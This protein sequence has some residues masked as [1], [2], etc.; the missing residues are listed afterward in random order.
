MIVPQHDDYPRE[1][2][3]DNPRTITW[4]HLSDLHS[5]KTKTGWDAHRVLMSL[6]DDLASS[7]IR[8]KLAAVASLFDHHCEV[9]AVSH[10]PVRGIKRPKSDNNEG[11]TPAL[12]GGQ[13]RAL[14]E[15]PPEDTLKGNATR[16]S[17]RRFFTTACG[18]RSSA[19]CG[20]A[21]F[22]AAKACPTCVF[23]ERAQR[24]ATCRPTRWPS[25]A[26]T[27][28]FKPP[29]TARTRTGRRSDPRTAPPFGWHTN[30][31]RPE[32]TC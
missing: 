16:P 27:I 3:S 12:G 10:N 5:C 28:T 30:A 13:A 2:R 18:A 23:S 20:C 17:W 29:A 7:S 9:N 11:K 6:R 25:S 24:C 14:R 8:R 1:C 15:A 21:T 19:A 31:L 4:L 22:K 26:F 32:N